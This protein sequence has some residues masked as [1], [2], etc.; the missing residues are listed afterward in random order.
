MWLYIFFSMGNNAFAQ[1]N[2]GPDNQ[3]WLLKVGGILNKE[4]V[5][6]N[7][8]TAIPYAGINWGGTASV[9]YQKE[10]VSHEVECYFS[11][12]N[13]K[14]AVNPESSL[15]NSYFNLDYNNLYTIGSN[16]A[17]SVL[18]MA[19]GSLNILYARRDYAAFI[20]N[21]SSF[22]FAASLGGATEFCYFFN[23]RLSGFSLSDRIN[24]PLVSAVV[25]PAFGSDNAAGVL[26]QNGLS[27]KDLF[28]YERIVSFSSFMRI[29][30]LLSIDKMI[31][32]RQK[33]SFN[34]AWDYY[35]ISGTREVKQAI[36]SLGL[37]YSFIF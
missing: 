24:I 2:D 30:N 19:G 29:K 22:E 3:K 36:H 33:I 37:T 12:G 21:N 6:D 20:N 1:K 27:A 4:S 25:Q 23:N 5:V 35:Q 28:N 32:P 13:L 10:K 31:G 18:L 8:F 26:N 7:T 17:G 9:K 34:Y 14:T 16:S 15:S 11:K